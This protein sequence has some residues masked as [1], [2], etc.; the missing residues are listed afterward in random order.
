MCVIAA[1]RHSFLSASWQLAVPQPVVLRT[2]VT[3]ALD[4][5][6]KWV[7][8]EGAEGNSGRENLTG[9]ASV[10]APITSSHQDAS[11]GRGRRGLG[12]GRWRMLMTHSSSETNDLLIREQLT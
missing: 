4:K 9:V 11:M 7:T 12:K 3:E 6:E 2:T 10:D 5:H 1:L 8:V